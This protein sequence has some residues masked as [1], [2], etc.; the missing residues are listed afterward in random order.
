MK[1]II[2]TLST[3]L[4]STSAFALGALN[5]SN[6][7]RTFVREEQEIWGANPIYY[8]INGEKVQVVKEIFDVGSKKVLSSKIDVE[9]EAGEEIYTIKMTLQLSDNK[10]QSDVVICRKW[11]NASID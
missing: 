9:T 2:I 7:D 4:L 6:A 5:C 8:F 10:R 1:T 3:I 11:W